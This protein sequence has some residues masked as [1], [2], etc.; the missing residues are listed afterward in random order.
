MSKCGKCPWNSGSSFKVAFW[1]SHRLSFTRL[2]FWKCATWEQGLFSTSHNSWEIHSPQKTQN[3]NG[4]WQDEHRHP[5]VLRRNRKA[6]K[7][8]YPL[9]RDSQDSEG[10][11][12]VVDFVPED[13]VV[14]SQRWLGGTFWGSGEWADTDERSIVR[15]YD[16]ESFNI[17]Q[18]KREWIG[19]FI[20]IILYMLNHA[21]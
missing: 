5:G 15:V 10:A 13:A 14:R 6:Q 7:G 3:Y 21:F 8:E 11:W 12:W 18:E 20:Y 9:R 1:L 17:I 19:E 4:E 16:L 2:P